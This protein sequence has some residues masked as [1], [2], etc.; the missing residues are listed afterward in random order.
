MVQN[1]NYDV[2][3]G[4]DLSAIFYPLSSE[5][6]PQTTPSGFQYWVTK[7]QWFNR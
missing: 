7:Y 4:I 5:G 2:S 3:G 1:T 6:T